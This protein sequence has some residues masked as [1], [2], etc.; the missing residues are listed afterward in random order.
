MKILSLLLIL[1]TFS[2]TSLAQTKVDEYERLDSDSESM[3]ILY[4]LGKLKEEPEW[5]GLIVV[6]SGEKETNLKYALQ[7]IEGIKQYLRIWK[8]TTTE[9]VK[10]QIVEGKKPLFKEFWIYRK[11]ERLPESESKNY[12]HR[13]FANKISFCINLR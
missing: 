3:R 1:L 9:K 5:K 13:L 12:K 4:F 7:H 6:Y 11:D 8:L 10:F 2:Q